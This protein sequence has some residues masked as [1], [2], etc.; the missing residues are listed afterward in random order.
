MVGKYIFKNNK[1]IGSI[2][3]LTKRKEKPYYRKFISYMIAKMTRNKGQRVEDVKVHCA[4]IY[5][6][7]NILYV[8]DMDKKGDEHYTLKDY[9]LKFQNRIE[10]YKPLF[11][12]GDWNINRFNKSCKDEKVK[13]DYINTFVYQVIKKYIHK[14]I[15]KD[16]SYTRMC[17]EDAQRQY[18]LLLPNYFKTPEA[19]SPNE[20]HGKI[21]KDGWQVINFISFN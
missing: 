12:F 16:T 19:T 21:V 1:M 8:R 10:I 7:D 20:V 13:Y 4:I 9:I 6:Y 3:F 5:R 15:G 2:I 18:N 11:E 14:F 17:A